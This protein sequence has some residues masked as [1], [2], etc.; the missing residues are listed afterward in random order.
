MENS[1][2][3]EVCNVKC[4]RASFAKH[5]RSKKYF[6]NKITI[7]QWLFQ[8]PIEDGIE[9]VYNPKTLRQIAR[10]YIKMKDEELNKELA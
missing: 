2:R 5:L 7:P 1:R 3:C 9:K 8:E 6:D 4:H 10:A